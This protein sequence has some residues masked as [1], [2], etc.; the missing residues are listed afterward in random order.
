EVYRAR[1]TRLGRDVA[2]K[3]LPLPLNSNADVRARFEREAKTV[4]S[5][6]HPNICTLFDVGREGE[7]DYLVMELVEG[8]T[9]AAR[10]AK[11]PLPL[12]DVLKL[13]AQIADALD[14][15]HR[16]GVV[17][18]D[19]KPGNVM[20]GKGGAKLMDF[21]LARAT[22]TAGPVSGSGATM[23][24]LTQSPTRASPLTAE[25][26]L[27]GTFQYM[28]PEQL[29][30]KEADSRADLWALGCVL[31][32]MATGERAYEGATQ[33]SL[34]S[35]IMRDTPRPISELAPM[36]PPALE[37]LVLQCLAKDP[38]ERWQ[39]AGD[40]RR[41]LA[42]IAGGG[43][44]SGAHSQPEIR[45][46]ARAVNTGLLGVA[47]GVVVALAA[48]FFAFG[49]W[50]A[51]PPSS[52]LA[53][54]LIG[55][56]EGTFLTQ[57]AEAELAPDGKSFVFVVFD[58]AGLRHLYVRPLDLPQ[59]R[60]IPGTEGASLP[61]WSP[62]ARSIAFFAGAKLRK[63]ARDG[64]A[65][66]VICD[67]PDGRGG[68]WSNASVIIFAPDREGGLMQVS[69]S[70][71]QPTGVT[72]LEKSRG[73]LG[74]RYP[75]FLPDGKHFLY[76]AIGTGDE[77]ITY[78]TSLAGGASVE[79]CRGGS[80]AHYVEPGYLL[81]L[82]SGVN[83]PQ[84][85]LLAR[86]FNPSARRASGQAQVVLDDVDANNFGY[87]NVSSSAQ[88]ALV[89]QHWNAP[90]LVLTWRSPSGAVSG[91]AVADLD[92][93]DPS[94][95]P[96]GKRVAYQLNNPLDVGVL[97][98][99]SGVSNRITYEKKALASLQWSADGRKLAFSRLLG[100]RGWEIH[101]KAADG[102]GPDSLV[103]HGPGLFAFPFAWAPD[104]NSLLAQCSDAQG[105]LDLWRVPLLGGAAEPFERS[106]AV[107]QWADYSSD[108]SLVLFGSDEN[109]KRACFIRSATDPGARYQL[110]FPS[111]A[112]AG[113]ARSGNDLIFLI[114]TAGHL[115]SCAVSFKDGF[116]Q[117]A[118]VLLCT[119]PS[120]ETIVG[121]DSAS[122]RFLTTREKEGSVQTQLE[123]V[124]GWRELLEK[125]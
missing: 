102:G 125:R 118:P 47:A 68:S 122:Q 40:V 80:V 62:D 31:Y 84:R 37:R 106:P 32:E 73:E 22:V 79:V 16:A 117:S 2:V 104:G 10:L 111:L 78:A 54:F 91:V 67:A 23:G 50:R 33:A 56:P 29:E 116:H 11:G 61:F 124:L 8:E 15:A 119:V 86:R 98:L 114:D 82:D 19:L 100:A 115:Y 97:D 58:S 24:A 26:T 101:T 49:P 12:P 13:G 113:W 1:D 45:P 59:A 89:V 43:S 108:G 103:Y 39:S 99:A 63:V 87:P 42:W 90:R 112:R 105:G 57:P 34:I 76:T 72:R 120:A 27:V 18:R 60:L 93:Q 36:S 9:L 17:H 83:S 35:A 46:R 7:T 65:S 71:G 28:S 121:Y 77:Q 64:S 4:S 94:L 109:G 74:H 81:Y 70:G 20:V 21:G 6:N 53:R 5:L 55:A 69:S 96:D 92:G 41:E 75:Q 51:K 110:F 44:S 48:L 14:R 52:S 30:G 107:E 123:V 85:R 3:E 38:D 88:G 95:S 25:G 66:V